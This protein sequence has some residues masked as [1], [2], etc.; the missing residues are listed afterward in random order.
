MAGRKAVEGWRVVEFGPHSFGIEHGTDKVLV[1]AIDLIGGLWHV[2]ILRPSGTINGNFA[3]YD[4]ALAF[5]EIAF[6]ET[7]I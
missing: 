1:G 5:V 2:D 7:S 4:A 3:E 6:A